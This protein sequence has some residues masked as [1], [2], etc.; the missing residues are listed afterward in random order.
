[1]YNR[2]VGYSYD[3]V[4]IFLPAGAEPT[5]SVCR[6]KVETPPRRRMAPAPLSAHE[7]R[8]QRFGIGEAMSAVETTGER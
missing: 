5:A 4:K 8:S 6:L 1:L 2:A 3:A 7:R